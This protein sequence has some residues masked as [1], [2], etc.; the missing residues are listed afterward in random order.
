LRTA[1]L[2]ITL[3]CVGPLAWIASIRSRIERQR[4]AIAAV[5]NLGGYVETD[6]SPLSRW[7]VVRALFGEGAFDIVD[8]V[9]FRADAQVAATDLSLLGAFSH[10]KRLY[11]ADGTT[12]EGLHHVAALTSLEELVIAK[13]RITDSG[14]AQLALLE[15]LTYLDI[16]QSCVTDAGLEH[17]SRHANLQWLDVSG[18]KITDR[19]LKHLGSLSKLHSLYLRGTQISDQGIHHLLVFSALDELSLKDTN[20]SDQGIMQ[21]EKAPTLTIVDLSGTSVTEYGAFKL[22]KA[23]PKLRIIMQL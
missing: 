18:T 6:D 9:A 23:L 13:S 7:L 12:D 22:K 19:G 5:Q 3:L 14:I 2:A 10:L 21:L 4:T 1:V 11:L 16:E 17:I 8:R 20:V 15:S